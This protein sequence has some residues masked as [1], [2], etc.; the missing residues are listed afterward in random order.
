MEALS[1]LD[2]T[3]TKGALSRQEL[4]WHTIDI[5]SDHLAIGIT[6]QAKSDRITTAPTVQA[7]DTKKA[8]WELFSGFLKQTETT[9]PDTPDLELLA[10]TFTDVISDAVKDGIPRSRK[11]LR[12]KPW[13]TPELRDPR[14]GLAKS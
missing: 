1:V 10:T 11:S 8:D 13:W 6:I 14:K 9:I 12:S 4:N 3:L 5:G 2:L 7:Y